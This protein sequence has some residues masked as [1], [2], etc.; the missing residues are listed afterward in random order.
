MTRPVQRVGGR[1]L[2]ALACAAA[3]SAAAAWQPIVPLITFPSPPPPARNAPHQLLVDRAAA[4]ALGVEAAQPLFS[5]AVPSTVAVQATARVVVRGPLPAAGGGAPAVVWDSGDVATV[6]PSL[7]YGGPPLA[8]ATRYSWTVQ[9]TAAG[10][11]GGGSAASDPSAP[12]EFVTGLL[13]QLQAS[14][15][16]VPL[17]AP[18]GAGGGGAAPNNSAMFVFLRAEVPLARPAADVAWAVVFTTAS[19][20]VSPSSAEIDN[21]KLLGAYKLWVNGALVGVGP[22]K[23]SRCG[24]LCPT[25][26]ATGNCTCV[27]EQLYDARDVT[28]LVSGGSGGNGT[29]TLALAGFNYPPVP[30]APTDSRILLEA[31]VAFTDGTKQ[32]VGSEAT[33]GA[34]RALDATAYMRPSGNFGMGAWYVSPRENFDARAEPVGWRL[35]GYDASGWAPAA[36]VAAFPAPLVAR[37]SLA[38]AITDDPSTVAPPVAVLFYG[39][40]VFADFG[41]DFTGG[42]CLDVENGVDGL[43]LLMALGEE[44]DDTGSGANATR[45]VAKMRTGNNYT[46]EWTLR[47]GGPQTLCMHEY[48][49]FRYVQFTAIGNGTSPPPPLGPL[50]LTIRAWVVYYPAQYVPAAAF[51]VAS[52]G[53]AAPGAPGGDGDATALA[54]VWGLSWYT[55]AAQGMDMYF[56][57]VRQRDVYC[58]EE[59]TVDLLQ[60]YALS[61]EWRLQPLTL[62]Y[63]LNNRP[64]DL[65]WAEWPALALFSVHEIYT[66]TGDLGLFVAHYDQLRRFSSL[67]LVN[68]TAG[69]GSGLWTCNET[70]PVLQCDKPE[71]DWPPTSRDGFVFTPTNTVVNAIVYRA[72]GMFAELAAAAGGH[73][74]DAA[75]FA[76]AAVDLRAAINARLWDAGAGAYVDGLTTSHASWHASAFALGMGV[77]TPELVPA[78]VQAV[79]RRMPAGGNASAAVCFPSNVWP[80]QWVLEGLY[81]YAR[82][83]HGR[84][85]L[86]VLTCDRP[87]GWVAMLAANFTQAPEAWNDAVKGNEELGMT[88]GAAPGDVLPRLLLG[89]LPGSPGFASAAVRPQPGDLGSVSGTVPTLRGPITVAYEQT[90]NGAAGA[91]WAVLTA[92]LSLALPGNLPTTACLPASACAGG[93]VGVDGVGTPSFADGDYACVNVTAAPTGTG[94]PRRLQCP[95]VAPAVVAA[96]AATA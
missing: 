15:P 91:E 93:V 30:A 32:V 69:G 92:S 53:A 17:W 4:P 1:A 60:Q 37:P 28:A 11:G 45:S 34:W 10:S 2:F 95:Y 86:A 75:L 56:D 64:D 83:D 85:G 55:R 21:A 13:G 22:G 9:V 77:P 38:L 81:T 72:L 6:Q 66:H 19:P 61:A 41:V 18:G 63:V 46:Q 89:V 87:Q 44:E 47:G 73:D 88:W 31:H 40:R 26:H 58:V 94:A 23:P 43:T 20:Q 90:T 57:H 62:A 80:T 51:A 42:A 49:Q 76:A 27:P 12:A 33:T 39:A 78:A 54:G 84:L 25:Q 67:A 5:W 3:A 74:A 50:G 48:A 71:V 16:T 68:A 8:P 35:P 70:A 24:P 82:D 59:L 52:N 96:T 14:P 36:G 65:G 7:A 79:V 29:L